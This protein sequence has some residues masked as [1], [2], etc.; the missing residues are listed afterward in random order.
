MSNAVSKL[1]VG[2]VIKAKHGSW[3]VLGTPVY[4]HPSTCDGKPVYKVPAYYE[5]KNGS[6]RAVTL[7]VHEDDT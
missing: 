2:S 4:S 6:H 1:V 5:G 7:T 3:T